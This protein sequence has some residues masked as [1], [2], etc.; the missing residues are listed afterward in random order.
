MSETIPL[1]SALGVQL[2]FIVIGNAFRQWLDGMFEFLPTETWLFGNVQWET[3]YL[4]VSMGCYMVR[5]G[6]RAYSNG[7]ISPVL[8]SADAAL[9]LCGVK[10]FNLPIYHRY[11]S[12]RLLML[13]HFPSGTSQH[14]AQGQRKR[15]T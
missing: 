2:I 7:T 8:I 3:V 13:N 4:A 1:G 12:Y 14:E 10:R 5:E 15:I 6:G 11:I 9:T